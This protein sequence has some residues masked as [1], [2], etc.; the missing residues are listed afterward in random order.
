LLAK[1]GLLL[2]QLKDIRGVHCTVEELTSCPVA[3][4]HACK[5][6]CR[7]WKKK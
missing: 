4:F 5:E 6:G 1:D 7:I 2:L 3:A